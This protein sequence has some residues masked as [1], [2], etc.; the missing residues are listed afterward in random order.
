MYVLLFFLSKLRSHPS[1]RIV[2]EDRQVVGATGEESYN[3]LFS[4]VEAV[5]GPFEGV[6]WHL[7]RLDQRELPLDNQFKPVLTGKGVD[8]YILDTGIRYD[9]DEFDGRAKYVGF[10]PMDE[11][12]VDSRPMQG[13]D[14]Y[15]HGT[16]IAS[17]V[18]GRTFGVAKE[19]TVFSVRTL[20]CNNSALW[21]AVLSSLERV[22]NFIKSNQRPSVISLSFIGAYNKAVN[23]VIADIVTGG[24]PVV[25][26]AGNIGGGDACD[27]S[28]ASSP[29]AITVAASDSEDYLFMDYP[30]S[31]VG[32]CVD[33]IAPGV[34]VCVWV[35]VGGWVRVCVCMCVY[36]LCIWYLCM[37]THTSMIHCMLLSTR[38][39]LTSM[40]ESIP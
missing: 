27:Y 33:I 38:T 5:E 14:C 24:I 34:C 10:D 29:F 40:Q 13:T 6:P 21:S 7:D 35:L 9:H 15:G 31:A 19:A 28:P 20:Q 11:L 30:G 22:T 16:H 26:A 4:D 37:R 2:E 12:N 17:I 39:L 8:V 18:G 23:D 36:V 25:V 1:V 3:S 32:P